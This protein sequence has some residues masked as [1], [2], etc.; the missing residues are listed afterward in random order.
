MTCTKLVMD[1]MP[2]IVCT[3][4]RRAT[5]HALRCEHRGCKANAQYLCAICGVLVCPRHGVAPSEAEQFC[6]RCGD[7]A[8]VAGVQHELF[9]SVRPRGK[10]PA[11]DGPV[12]G[13]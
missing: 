6:L 11:L 3:G 10:R 2:V 5:R 9:T 12:K 13:A 8:G 1:G 4:K 7:V